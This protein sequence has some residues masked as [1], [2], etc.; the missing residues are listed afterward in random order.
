MAEKAYA[1]AV[2]LLLRF[3]AR[4]TSKGR[5]G[6]LDPKGYHHPE[7]YFALGNAY[8]LQAN[9]AAAATAY[10]GALRRDPNHTYAWL[11]LA[12]TH[13]ELERFAEAGRC[14][15]EGYASEG[16]KHPR[17]LYNSAAAYLMGDEAQEALRRFEALFAAHPEALELEWRAAYVHALLATDQAR[18]ALPHIH[19]LADAYTGEKQIQW[20]EILLFQY[21]HLEM[22]TQALAYATRLTRTAPENPKWW[23]ALAHIQ[24][25]VQQ[26]VEALAALTLYGFLVPLTAEEKQLLAD[27]H[28][29]AGIPVKA[30]P[31]Y[32]ELLEDGGETAHL[33]RL[34]MAYRQL[35]RP[36]TALASLEALGAAKLSADPALLL[37]KG[38][39]LFGLKRYAEAAEVCRRAVRH[40]K[41]KG[42]A[43]LLAGYAAWQM[44]DIPASREAFVQAAGYRQ[45][46]KAARAALR[47][48]PPP[49]AAVGGRRRGPTAMKERG[50]HVKAGTEPKL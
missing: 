47:E 14:F 37:L 29:Q 45:S 5:P 1:K 17:Y 26:P 39:L 36:E 10:E 18:Q 28:L 35:G 22:M 41:Q 4:S 49:A 23:K 31:L 16:G 21:M 12:K 32:E 44:D 9:P 6:E 38:E 19:E 40:G 24:L 20:Q 25:E 43:L 27:L 48:L 46:Q 34:V 8:L 30:A 7:I 15:A 42:R 2:D 13:Y 33:Q 3:Q 50:D 11:N